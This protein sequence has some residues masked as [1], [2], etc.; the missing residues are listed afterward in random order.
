M[1]CPHCEHL[2]LCHYLGH[3]F[4]VEN[5]CSLRPNPELF[6]SVHSRCRGLG[7]TGGV[8][9]GCRELGGMGGVQ[10]GLQ[11]AGRD[12]RGAGGWEG[13]EGCRGGCRGLG[14]MGGVQQN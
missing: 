7:G 13:W 6:L 12:G 5:F 9:G 11:E 10:G 8:Q 2:H 1:I 14:G 3:G 4:E